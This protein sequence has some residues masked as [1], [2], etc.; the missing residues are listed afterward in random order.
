MAD[1]NNRR[2]V[3]Y[4]L[5]HQPTGQLFLRSPTGRFQIKEIRDISSGGIST[6]LDRAVPASAKVAI[7]YA[8]GKV[9]VEVN[10]TVAWCSEREEGKTHQEQRIDR[11]V[12]GIQLLSPLMLYMMLNLP[13]GVA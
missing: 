5:E 11:F 1:F 10:G 6:Y 3:R 2:E 8:D 7:E 9:R 4:P 13:S 12:L